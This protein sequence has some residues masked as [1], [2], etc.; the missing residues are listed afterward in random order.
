MIRTS[1][2]HTN[3]QMSIDGRGGMTYAMLISQTESCTRIPF[4]MKTIKRVRKPRHNGGGGDC[5]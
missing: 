5:R 3:D 1:A 4:V 2:A